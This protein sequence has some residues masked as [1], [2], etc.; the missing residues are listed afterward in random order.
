MSKDI[1]RYFQGSTRTCTGAT[2]N[3]APISSSSLSQQNNNNN[4]MAPKPLSVVTDTDPETIKVFDK[5]L[6]GLALLLFVIVWLSS[7]LSPILFV[8]ALYQGA[9]LSALFIALA[10]IFAYLPWEKGTTA[11][12]LQKFLSQYSPLYMRKTSIVFEGDKPT[13]KPDAQTF[14]AI[15]PHG[16]GFSHIS[17]HNLLCTENTIRQLTN[18]PCIHKK[19]LSVLGGR[20]CMFMM[21]CSM[22]DFAFLR[23]YLY[24][25][26]L[27]CSVAA[28]ATQARPPSLL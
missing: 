20:S 17:Q 14:Y 23:H 6:G 21:L 11:K 22:C 18:Q 25:P 8:V 10:T 15:H 24:P 19:E 9:Y 3:P 16:K 13:A 12:A 5:A 7:A 27:G 2:W 1:V 26:F 4:I 28:A